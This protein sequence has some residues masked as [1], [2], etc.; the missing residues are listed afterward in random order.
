MED[1]NYACALYQVNEVIKHMEETLK[2]KIPETYISYIEQNKAKNYN[3]IYNE[4]Q[5]LYNQDL[6]PKAKSIL[7]V[8]YQDFLCNEEEKEKLKL[9]LAN[10]ENKFQEQ[11]KKKYNSD[12]LFKNKNLEKNSAINSDISTTTQSKYNNENIDN[13][14]IKKEN[15]EITEYKE[16]FL[17]KLINKIRKMVK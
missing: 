15:M 17:K 13:E 3:W 7:T 8:L 6:L 10:N 11:T 2:D 14:K 4:S 16:S 1:T 12:N 5:E 9:I